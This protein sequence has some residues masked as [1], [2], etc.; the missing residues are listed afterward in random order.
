MMM[1]IIMM[2]MVVM[3]YDDDQNQAVPG[4]G[5]EETGESLTREELQEQERL[6]WIY[7]YEEVDEDEEEEEEDVNED[8]DKVDFTEGFNEKL[9]VDYDDIESVLIHE[10]PKRMEATKASM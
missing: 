5:K 7:A 10:N 1:V 2:M 3:M 4:T 8:T 9:H 6:R